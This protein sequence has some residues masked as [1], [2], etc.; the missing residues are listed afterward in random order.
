MAEI[1]DP[2]GE[3]PHRREYY[4]IEAFEVREKALTNEAK[5]PIRSYMLP[6]GSRETIVE[7]GMTRNLVFREKNLK[8]DEDQVTTWYLFYSIVWRNSSVGM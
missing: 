5:K 3:L 4:V 6:L 8:K 2:V 7:I 1:Y